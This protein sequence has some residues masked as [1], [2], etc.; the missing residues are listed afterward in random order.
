VEVRNPVLVVVD[1]QNGFLNEHSES[2]I[3]FVVRLVKECAKRKVP[4]VFTAFRNEPDSPFERLIGWDNVRQK[5]E[6]D[7]YEAFQSYAEV[8][9]EKS[10]YTAFTDEFDS[11]L[12][13]RGWMTILICG[14]TTESCVLKTAVDAF[15]RDLVPIVISD[16]CSS[17]LGSEMHRIGL[18][19]LEVLIG[20]KQIMT[21]DELLAKLN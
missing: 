15:E 7:L 18:A 12:R 6:T 1:M 10:Y 21:I 16:A 4:V 17:D 19:I 11:L 20:K 2:A 13:D 14:V 8:L 3:P 5:P 9:I